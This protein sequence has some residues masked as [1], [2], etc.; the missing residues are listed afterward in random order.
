LRRAAESYRKGER[1]L[2]HAVEFVTFN[3]AEAQPQNMENKNILAEQLEASFR[4][5]DLPRGEYFLNSSKKL[6]NI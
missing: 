4:F 6:A 2:V 3:H 1:E 5:P